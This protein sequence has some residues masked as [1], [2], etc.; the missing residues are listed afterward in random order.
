MNYP[1]HLHE[2]FT[3][4][5]I[6][7]RDYKLKAKPL[8]ELIGHEPKTPAS[9]QI[10]ITGKNIDTYSD[11]LFVIRCYSNTRDPEVPSEVRISTSG[12]LTQYMNRR[13]IT[14]CIKSMNDL[15]II[16]AVSDNELIKRKD[17]E[18]EFILNKKGKPTY[19]GVTSR[20]Y[21]WYPAN[22]FKIKKILTDK[23]LE[24]MT[25]QF[26]DTH[27]TTSI[28][29]DKIRFSSFVR[30]KRPTDME[31]MEL[32]SY[33][34]ARLSKNYPILSI[35]QS[36][37][38]L[39]NSHYINKPERIIHYTPTVHYSLGSKWVS[40]IGIRYFCDFCSYSKEKKDYIPYRNDYLF[41]EGLDLHYDVKGS[42]PKISSLI[43]FG[44]W[45][46]NSED[47]YEL[48]S[49][50]YNQISGEIDNPWDSRQRCAIK[51]IFVRVYF[52]R[53]VATAT[54]NAKKYIEDRGHSIGKEELSNY[55]SNINKAITSCFG[56][57]LGS[58][59]FFHESNVYILALEKLLND[60]FDVVTCFDSFYA[61]K[62]G[63]S[64][65]D[66]N[67]YMDKLLEDCAFKYLE[68]LHLHKGTF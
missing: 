36:K 26:S 20:S 14:K 52:E 17:S 46:D 44:T 43:N 34:N 49:N 42:V 65:K 7:T 25:P 29:D 4:E 13:R 32:T 58:E 16:V 61:H 39:I 8:P 15:G 35:I 9:N 5:K 22:E 27:K 55:L 18:G 37:V 64:Q 28:S 50:T 56:K 68:M 40:G 21:V 1:I 2:L 54:N 63:V 11:V 6:Y 30:F 67:S 45:S 3:Y 47:P 24:P 19:T 66:F 53:S 51:D 23:G 62:K 57:S 48:M 60:G 10:K 41:S 38:A 12:F 31:P 33:I 59:V